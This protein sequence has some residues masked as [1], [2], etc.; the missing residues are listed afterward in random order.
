MTDPV[1]EWRHAWRRLRRTPIFSLTTVLVVALGVGATTALFSLVDG[2]L[3]RPL[4][5]P[6][7]ERLVDLSHS[8]VVPGLTHVNQSDAT[9]LLYQRHNQTFDGMAAYRVDEVNLSSVSGGADAERVGGA[10]VSASLLSVLQSGPLL[11]RGFVDGEDRVDAARVVLL[12]ERVWRAK[13]AADPALV[14]RRV[15]I[16]GVPSEVVGIMPSAFRFPAASTVLWMP[17]RF[18]PAHSDPGYYKYRAVAR[19]RPGATLDAAAADLDRILPRLFDEFP[20]DIPPAVYASQHLRTVAAPLRQ[21]IVADVRLLLWVLF[22]ASGLLLLIACANVAN[23]FLV[24]SEAR[25]RDLA[26]RTALGASAIELLAPQISE[27]ALLVGIGGAAGV[28]V[29]GAAVRSLTALPRAMTLPLRDAI[30]LDAGVL[31][32]AAALTLVTALCVS[33]LPMLR[34]RRAPTASALQDAGRSV[35]DSPARRLSRHALIVAQVAFALVLAAGAGLMLRSVTHL[36]RVRPGFEAQHVLTLRVAMPEATYATVSAR[37]QYYDRMVA[38]VGAVPGVG[39][40]GLTTWLPLGAGIRRPVLEVEDHPVPKN[41]VPRVHVQALVGNAWFNAMGIP[42]LSGRAF[43]AQDAG[44]PVP[45]AIVSRAFAAR[46]WQEA[47]PLGKRIRPG[48][49]G[50]WFTIVG[51]VGDVHLESLDMPAEEAAYFPM[52]MPDDPADGTTPS[53]MAVAARTDGDPAA[54]IAAVRGAI[55]RIDPAVPTFQ[56]QPMRDILAGATART[57]FTTWLLAA[58]SAI[59]LAVG[60]VGIYGVIAYGVSL[61]RREMGVRMALGARPADVRRMISREGLL[62]AAAGIGAGLLLTVAVTRF[63][64]GLLYEVSTVDPVAL[65]AAS[66]LLLGVALVASWLPAFAVS[67]VEPS[68]ALRAE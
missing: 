3:L 20:N 15:L 12:S 19:L 44:R 25:S 37:M 48:I 59:A 9:F 18:D 28:A 53:T 55:H 39:A 42:L 45:E 27:A 23:L 33:V 13:F 21:V 60:A 36:R 67:R 8:L 22:G 31:A 57:R 50:P 38:A 1:R 30:V 65:G 58:A 56:E 7:A 32:F 10:S 34:A 14:G 66:A 49:S 29:A 16:D 24:R 40:V 41:T 62:L 54:L 26:V 61:R 2:V 4:P 63:M 47:S 5:Y 35:T 46:Y 68:S 64:R 43:G 11:G 17:A 6:H 52:V 51:L